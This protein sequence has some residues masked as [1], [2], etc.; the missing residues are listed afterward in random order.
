MVPAKNP[1]A[2]VGLS[3][4]GQGESG[5]GSIPVK[6]KIQNHWLT[7][8]KDVVVR[9]VDSEKYLFEEV[10]P[11]VEPGEHEYTLTNRI[12][13]TM[14]TPSYLRVALQGDD[15][16]ATDNEMTTFAIYD[17]YCIPPSLPK[18]GAVIQSVSALDR[19]VTLNLARTGLMRYALDEPIVLYKGEPH[20]EIEVGLGGRIPEGYSLAA[21]VEWDNNGIFEESEKQAC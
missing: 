13:A 2:L 17:R 6:L 10:I 21:F 12:A 14:S 4:T 3:A 20:A 8:Q 18:K 5:V 7:A 16:D 15:T 1:L 9:A 11:T 19:M